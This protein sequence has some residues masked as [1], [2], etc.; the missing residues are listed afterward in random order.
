MTTTKKPLL[1]RKSFFAILLV[2]AF[3]FSL[4]AG[5]VAGSRAAAEQTPLTVKCASTTSSDKLLTACAASSAGGKNQVPALRWN[6]VPGA[7]CYAVYMFDISA[8]NWCHWICGG[9]TTTE[10]QQGAA[11]SGCRYKGPYPPSGT[12]TYR[13]FV[14]AL[15]EPLPSYP[16]AFDAKN[17]S[18][19]AVE[20]KLAGDHHNIL[21]KGSV[22]VKYAK[23]DKNV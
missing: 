16:G 9:L 10:I 22:D 14:Y 2:A 18:I 15:K 6:A 23:G 19:S 7:A 11:L 8:G 5:A 17:S 1:A 13:I 3:V 4:F 20:S 21:A 12:H